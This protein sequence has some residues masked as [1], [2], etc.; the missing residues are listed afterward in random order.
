MSINVK[1]SDIEEALK[2]YQKA[3]K[4]LNEQQ[5]NLTNISTAVVAAW[6]GNGATQWQQNFA[7]YANN[8]IS[9]ALQ[10]LGVIIPALQNVESAAKAIVKEASV[11]ESNLA[12]G[13]SSPI[14]KEVYLDN[15]YVGANVDI[16]ADL[17]TALQGLE[18]KYDTVDNDTNNLA[19]GILMLF[20]SPSPQS[21]LPSTVSNLQAEADNLN[22]AQLRC[23]ADMFNMAQ[24]FT[25]ATAN[26][27]WCNNDANAQTFNAAI[28]TYESN[29]NVDGDATLNKLFTLPAYDPIS[30]STGAFEQTLPLLSIGGPIPLDFSLSYS[31]L[32]RR[33]TY[34]GMGWLHSFDWL[35]TDRVDTIS[36]VAGSGLEQVFRL[37]PDGSYLNITGPVETLEHAVEGYIYHQHDGNSIRFDQNGRLTAFKDTHNNRINCEYDS[38]QRLATLKVCPTDGHGQRQVDLAYDQDG[39]LIAI[40]DSRGQK[41]QLLYRNNQLCTCINAKG[42]TASLGY[43]QNGYLNHVSLNGKRLLDN[44]YDP[45]GRAIEQTL[46]DESVAELTYAPDQGHTTTTD[47]DGQALYDFDKRL[48]TVAIHKPSGTE[49]Y[50]YNLRSQ[51]SQFTNIHGQEESYTY[52]KLGNLSSIKGPNGDSFF[53]YDSFAHILDKTEPSGYYHYGYN[54]QGDMT[55]AREAGL[56]VV[57]VSYD[58]AGRAVAFAVAGHTVATLSYD[59]NG[60]LASITDQENRSAHFSYD[61]KGRLQTTDNLSGHYEYDPS[62]RLTR[63]V[64]ALGNNH[65][66]D[67]NQDGHLTSISLNKQIKAS[68]SYN[69]QGQ[70]IGAEDAL[71]NLNSCTYNQDGQLAKQTDA[72]G[73][74]TEFTYDQ[75]G[76]LLSRQV[77]TDS[78]VFTYADKR[79]PKR[80][81]TSSDALQLVVDEEERPLHLDLGGGLSLEYTWDAVGHRTST[82]YPDQSQARYSYDSIGKL[83]RVDFQN[84]HIT[85]SYDKKGRLSRVE[86]PYQSEE[87][88]SYDSLNRVVLH[89]CLVQGRITDSC[90][91]QYDHYGNITSRYIQREGLPEADGVWRYEYDLCKR[92]TRVEHDGALVAEYAYD[93]RGNRVSERSV[94]GKIDYSYDAADRLST[95]KEGQI[96]RN[97]RYDANGR[98][99]QVFKDDI[100]EYDYAYDTWGQLESVQGPKGR[101]VYTYDAFGKLRSRSCNGHTEHFIFDPFAPSNNLLSWTHDGQQTNYL[102][103]SVALLALN[104]TSGKLDTAFR[105]HLGSPLRVLDETGCSLSSYSFDEFGVSQK[106]EGLCGQNGIESCSP[107]LPFGFTGYLEDEACGGYYA[108]ARRYLPTLGRFNSKDFKKGH[109]PQPQS[110]NEYVYCMNRP[111]SMVDRDGLEP[112]EAGNNDAG[113]T[114]SPWDAPGAGSNVAI[115]GASNGS[116]TVYQHIGGNDTVSTTDSEGTSVETEL[117]HIGTDDVND[118]LSTGTDAEGHATLTISDKD[119][120]SS[121]ATINTIEVAVGGD[122]ITITSKSIL[123]TLEVNPATKQPYSD[124]YLQTVVTNGSIKISWWEAALAAVG[125]VAVVAAVTVG[126]DGAGDVA[127]AT[128]IPAIMDMVTNLMAKGGAAVTAATTFVQSGC[129]LAAAGAGA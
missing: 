87:R 82:T 128:A 33:A 90:A 19:S 60:N 97:Y 73:Q 113:Q 20:P 42:A 67:Y 24:A 50:Q 52:D 109:L 83:S 71:G 112:S 3:Q 72:C 117:G 64:D 38:N 70:T 32:R 103:T 43:D 120:N 74:I 46:P 25:Q 9:A 92:L 121:S 5:P 18:A 35:L 114:T 62:G 22:S 91:Y 123:D 48:R 116:T 65:L 95:R 68:Y 59:N 115:P 10:D 47:K 58:V 111:L 98:L 125:I 129:P 21:S 12:P 106:N 31:S 37:Q 119:A 45:Q 66:Y 80:I 57:N 28:G 96:L 36:L 85:Y 34:M 11:L 118:S 101:T 2:G 15:G 30:T 8:M 29:L 7:L 44:L 77:G 27:V 127:I 1:L 40:A 4:I 124:Q 61:Q 79:I 88:Y 122:G 99:L 69:A 108:Q 63:I 39:H 84:A 17:D 23:Q 75:D 89:E 55:T 105:D 16:S 110:L 102:S 94:S 81:D 76:R 13:A 6:T 78:L 104:D 49:R 41:A 51:R 53:R 100:L 26:L 14:A 54:D 86:L 93:A 126:T 107:A 56:P